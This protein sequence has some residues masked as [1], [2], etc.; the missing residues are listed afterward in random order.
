M[1]YLFLWHRW[2][3]IALCLFMALWFVSGVV[4]LF[5]GYPKLTPAETVARLPVLSSEIRYIDVN[6]AIDATEQESPPR[7]VTLSSIAGSPYYLFSYPKQAVIAVHAVTG[8]R[9]NHIDEAQ[10]MASA[11]AFFD[12]SPPRYLG[13]I[14]QDAW[15]QSRG[16]D[17]ERPFYKVAVEDIDSRFLYI[18][19]HS[20]QIVRDA[21]FVERSWGWLG[22]WL[23]WI[24]PL[25]SLPWWGALVIYLSL[26][27]TA[28]SVLGQYL[29]L[30]RWRFSKTYRNGSHSPYPTGF[31]RWHHVGG[32]LFGGLLI[33]WVFSGLMS[34]RP[35][36]L[37]ANGSQINEATFYGGDLGHFDSSADP[38]Q[39]LKQFEQAGHD[40]RELVW[41]KVGGEA[42]LTAYD[43]NLA[44]KVVSLNQPEAVLSKIPTSSLQEAINGITTDSKAQIE[45]VEEYDFYYLAREQQ[46]MYGHYVRPLPM[47]RVRFDDEANTWLHIDPASGKILGS[48]DDNRRLSRWL[49]NL[50]HSWDWQ[51]LL[52]RPVVREVLMI[53]TSLG[54]FVICVS[55]IV[56]GWRRLTRQNKKAT[57]R[58]KQSHHEA[59]EASS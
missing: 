31:S 6:Q 9:V 57:K 1:R 49:F 45:W 3:G 42:W 25:R 58:P 18:S 59:V 16:L 39:L 2:L 53:A 36:G 15:T 43:K 7:S 22:A 13:L 8:E 17:A 56:V 47:L 11:R 33:A 14:E 51:P 37:F 30:K 23:H 32:M 54:G 20:G 29:G 35:W 41:H 12:D 48:L 19:S 5:V 46:S 40:S 21:T 38:Q 52:Q 26:A 10:A 55:G 44:S 34:M 4:M 50:L 24:Y 28:M 27:A